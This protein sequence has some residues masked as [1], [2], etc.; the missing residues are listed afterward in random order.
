MPHCLL[1]FLAPVDPEAYKA[2]RRHFLK[3]DVVPTVER[4][5]FYMQEQNMMTTN[6]TQKQSLI[7]S[8]RL[9]LIDKLNCGIMLTTTK[10]P[11]EKKKVEPWLG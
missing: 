8:V 3:Y 1:P 11:Q 10:I 9:R 6:I 2:V 4:V 5:S 7:V